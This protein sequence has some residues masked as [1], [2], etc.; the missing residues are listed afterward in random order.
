MNTETEQN[1]SSV[2][3]ATYGKLTISQKD[4]YTLSFNYEEVDKKNTNNPE[5]TDEIKIETKVEQSENKKDTRKHHEKKIDMFNDLMEKF[6]SVNKDDLMTY[7]KDMLKCI[8]SFYNISATHK[9]AEEIS[10]L[11]DF[12]ET[13]LEQIT[14]DNISEINETINIHMAQARFAY[15]YPY[16]LEDKREFNHKT[17][18]M[19]NDTVRLQLQYYTET[20]RWYVSINMSDSHWKLYKD[21]CSI[22]N[23]RFENKNT[24]IVCYNFKDQLIHFGTVSG[25]LRPR[26]RHYYGLY[27]HD[28]IMALPLIG[29]PLLETTVYLPYITY[30]KALDDMKKM[31]EYF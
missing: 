22:K 10:E 2:K 12:V 18:L 5:K 14:K 3:D 25:T 30:E 21:R 19:A 7:K 15:L 23:V 16:V 11:C 8:E 13:K 27:E 6:R 20:F 9:K 31:L 24:D 4:L 26:T 28:V 17:V 29:E 1:V